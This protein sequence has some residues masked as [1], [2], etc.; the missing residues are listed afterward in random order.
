MH[1]GSQVSCAKTGAPWLLP[2]VPGGPAEGPL[3]E[4]PEAEPQP[5]PRGTE[6]P[7]SP[8]EQGSARVAQGGSGC[9]GSWGRRRAAGG[10]PIRGNEV[11]GQPLPRPLAF[12]EPFCRLRAW[13]EEPPDHR[14]SPQG[15]ARVRKPLPPPT[16]PDTMPRPGPPRPTLPKEPREAPRWAERAGAQLG[17]GPR[18]Q[19]IQGT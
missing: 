14:D 6:R 4:A 12:P 15:C 5:R 2:S 1:N 19:S 18:A 8:G 3:L 9:L 13:V 7:R 17:T 11:R 16:G 10:A